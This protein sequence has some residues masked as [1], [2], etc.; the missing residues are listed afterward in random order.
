VFSSNGS[1]GGRTAAA[2]DS[3]GPS[4]LGIT[5]CEMASQETQQARACVQEMGK[6]RLNAAKQGETETKRKQGRN[7]LSLST[8]KDRKRTRKPPTLLP[9]IFVDVD[10]F[11]FHRVDLS[12]FETNEDPWP[13]KER[14]LVCIGGNFII[15]LRKQEP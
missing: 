6:N 12:G 2:F 4:Q 15:T 9:A 13:R 3:F 1:R 10:G 5:D 7:S 8:K 14:L 11:S